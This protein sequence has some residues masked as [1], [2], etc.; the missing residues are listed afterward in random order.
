MFNPFRPVSFKLSPIDYEFE[1]S[2]YLFIYLSIYLYTTVFGL[3]WYVLYSTLLPL[4]PSHFTLPEDAG[5]ELRTV[6]IPMR[7]KARGLTQHGGPPSWLEES[8]TR[9][10]WFCIR[11]VR[12]VPPVF[13]VPYRLPLTGAV[14]LRTD[15]ISSCW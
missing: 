4:P 9:Q 11:D 5:I 7:P 10:M 14:Q 3:D 15:G 13:F 8:V 6:A 1:L 2:I 12:A